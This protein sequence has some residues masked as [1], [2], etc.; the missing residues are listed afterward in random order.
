[1]E[2]VGWCRKMTSKKTHESTT[3]WNLPR[4]VASD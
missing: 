2:K 1:M 3:K 4:A